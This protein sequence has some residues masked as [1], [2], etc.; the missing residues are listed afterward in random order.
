MRM[1]R[2][3]LWGPP[4]AVVLALSY[5]PFGPLPAV[6]PLLD[7]ITGIW[8]AAH[9]AVSPGTAPVTIPTLT[10][11]VEGVIDRRGVP[12]LFAAIDLD[13]WRALGWLHARDRLFEM[14]LLSHATEGTL[15]EWVGAPGLRLDQ[16]M[17]R[18]GLAHLAD[19]LYQ[20][21]PDTAP[22]R[23]ALNAYAEGVNA[24]I[25]SLG[26]RDR[27]FE[28]HLLGVRPRPW[29]PVY[30]FYLAERMNY[31]LGWQD[32]DL[33][34]EAMATLVGERAAAALLPANAPI[35]RP[36]VPGPGNLPS[37]LPFDLPAPRVGAGRTHARMGVIAQG[38][39]GDL[40]VGSN[41]WVLAPSRTAG[42]HPLLAGDPHLDL[43]LPSLWYEAHLVTRDGL[44]IYGATLPGAPMVLIGL[45]RG[46]AWSFTNSEADFVDHYR[47]RVDDP[48]H[49][50]RHL[51]DGVWRP[52]ASRVEV[53]RDRRGR[54]IATDTLYRTERGPL[55]VYAG[56]WRST[57]WTALEASDPITP[58]LRLQRARNVGEFLAAMTTLEAPAQNG[59][60]A[61]TAGH[62][63]ELSAGRFPRRPNND[64]GVI[65]DGSS[66]RSDWTGELAPLPPVVDPP[67]GFL[68]SANQQIVDPRVDWVYRGNGWA[69]PWRAMRIARLAGAAHAAT[70]D[71]LRRWQTDPVSPRAEWWLPVLLR[72]AE[73]DPSLAAPRALLAGWTEG[74]RPSSRAAPLFEATMQEVA[75]LTWDELGVHDVVVAWPSA[76]VLASLRDH[77]TDIWWDRLSTTEREERDDILRLALHHAWDRLRADGRLG[78]DT[79]RWRWDRYRT[80]NIEHIAFLPGLGSGPLSV[81]GGDGTLSPLVDR[82]TH[83]ASWRMV[84]E[85]GPHPVA[86]TTY[87][88][89]QSGDPASPRYDDR[90][91]EWSR[92]A[93]DSARIPRTPEDLGAA[94]RAEVLRFVPGAATGSGHRWWPAGLWWV[95]PI[96]GAFTGVGAARR[97]ATPWWGALAGLLMW[98]GALA[99][100]WEP[101][102]SWRLATRLGALFGGVPP[103]VM[104]AIV[105]L[106]GALLSGLCARWTALFVERDP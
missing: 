7:P 1:R 96:L 90:L 6:A 12:H 2:A 19:S 5:L 77:P 86:W 32:T 102:A 3:L 11:P 21:L 67:G 13:A 103:W 34:R 93:L 48:L 82:G 4:V 27:P 50:T 51:V 64:G 72:A 83:G 36:I 61:D 69:P 68:F 91:G 14:D 17:R 97:G 104:V 24:R 94:D 63:A 38:P 70:L 53:Y 23:R 45:T 29:R 26:P 56:E 89:G 75:T 44:D 52:I 18:L 9:Q 65:F 98:G 101:E 76:A 62:I 35:Q 40:A 57:R 43:S 71:S 16:E 59:V 47:E 105:P 10:L 49:P 79:A 100:T 73:T 42:H 20:D 37:L 15:T 80:A 66:G 74:Y 55:K 92:G 31:T 8:G 88:G 106:W 81:T 58:F 87:P 41:N 95:L 28:Y 99:G 54:V 84:V 78:P 22:V 46:V 85:L 60:A 39:D 25:A 30:T 33:R